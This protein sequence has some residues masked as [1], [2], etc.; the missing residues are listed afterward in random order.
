VLPQMFYLVQLTSLNN[1]DYEKKEEK[2]KKKNQ[3]HPEEDFQLE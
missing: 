1:N 2:K 3:D